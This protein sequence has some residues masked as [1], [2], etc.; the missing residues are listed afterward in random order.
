M[1]AGDKDTDRMLFKQAMESVQPLDARH[2][3]RKVPQK[4]PR[5]GVDRPKAG[6]SIAPGN[7]LPRTLRRTASNPF[8]DVTP[9][10]G[11]VVYAR[12][13]LQKKVI[14]RL[15]RGL[16]QFQDIIDLHG[17]SRREAEEALESFILDS[18]ASGYRC[19]LIVHGKGRHSSSPGILKRFTMNWLKDIDPVLAFCTT[20]PEHGGTG[21][22][23]VLLKSRQSSESDAS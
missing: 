23:Y 21:S 8:L 17:Y 22:L 9:D 19:V 13:G 10:A 2:G 4:P 1:A 7:S 15:K 6:K 20:L 5:H 14:Q 12:S 18:V 16:F 3:N 11:P